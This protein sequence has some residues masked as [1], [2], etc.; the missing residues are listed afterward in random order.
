MFLAYFCGTTSCAQLLPG[1]ATAWARVKSG[2]AMLE[3]YKPDVSCVRIVCGGGG[4]SCAQLLP[5]EATAWAWVKS[6]VA[7][8]EVYQPNVSGVLLWCN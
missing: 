7:M 4:S 6:G 2:V 3:V 8:L 1:E 5:G